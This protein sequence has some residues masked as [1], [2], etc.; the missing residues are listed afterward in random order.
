MTDASIAQPR[1]RIF[2]ALYDRMLATAEATMRPLREFA[3]GGATGCV[4]EIGG[5]T[6]HNLRYYRWANVDSVEVTEPDPFMFQRAEARADRLEPAA[7]LK[8]MLRQAPAEA[9]PFADGSVD[10]VVSTLVLCTVSDVD[11]ALTEIWRVLRPGGQIR[12]VEHVRAAGGVAQVQRIVQPVY[13]WVAAGC[14]LSRDTESAV[15]RHG[16]DLEVTQRTTLGLP[17]WPTF[18]GIATKVQAR[19][20]TGSR[21]GFG[22]PG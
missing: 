16:F 6:G 9:L 18:L 8:L 19:T 17:L 22:S 14:Q 3:A 13:G 21:F 20:A 11:R 10:T 12:V 4:V 2:A 1:H 7:R 15:Q 5:G